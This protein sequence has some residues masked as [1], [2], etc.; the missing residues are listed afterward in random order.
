MQKQSNTPN[1]SPGELAL[2]PTVD[3]AL[4]AAISNHT[5]SA[6]VTEVQKCSVI[7]HQC[8]SNCMEIDESPTMKKKKKESGF[9][10]ADVM[11]SS[12]TFILY[13][14]IFKSNIAS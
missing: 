3:T 12:G 1:Y 14:T 8:N 5:V 4:I 9:S 6:G 13:I 7:T 11:I 10:K 2:S